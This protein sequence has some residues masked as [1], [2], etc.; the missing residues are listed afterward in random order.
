MM[1][2]YFLVSARVRAAEGISKAPG[3]RTTAMS[4]LLAPRRRRPSQAL[5]RR[6]SVMK[7]LKRETTRAKRLPRAFR[8][9]SRAGCAG[10]GGGSS[11]SLVFVSFS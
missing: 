4:F 7:A 8:W 6:R 9:P 11:L 10:V 2:S 5:C 1:A 3:T